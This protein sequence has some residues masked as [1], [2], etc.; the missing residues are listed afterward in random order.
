MSRTSPRVILPLATLSF[1][2]LAI[3]SC[4]QQGTP[5]APSSSLAGGPQP[6]VTE[7]FV[8]L[9]DPAPPSREPISSRESHR[10]AIPAPHP[11]P[12]TNREAQQPLGRQG[13][14]H[15]S[16]RVSRCQ[17]PQQCRTGSS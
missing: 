13:L 15:K 14:H 9:S 8:T 16:S 6:A 12:R 1:A 4:N 5:T 10:V 3:A 11:N 7:Y 2:A 17:R